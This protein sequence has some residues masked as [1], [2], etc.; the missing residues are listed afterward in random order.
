M[1]SGDGQHVKGEELDFFIMPA[2]VQSLASP[3]RSMDALK[4]N[5]RHAF[6][7]VSL[8]SREYAL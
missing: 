4:E 1:T 2:C 6:G 5:G 3:S 7:G 8:G